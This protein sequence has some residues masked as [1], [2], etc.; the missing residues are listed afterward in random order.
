M[1]QHNFKKQLGQNFLTKTEPILDFIEA[2]DPQAAD[3]ILEIGPGNGALSEYIAANVAYLHLL[4]IDTE[5][6]P[7]LQ[8]KFGFLDN[9][10]I[11]NQDV[12]KLNVSEFI[13]D[14]Q[15]NKIAGALPYNISKLIIAQF[16][17]NPDLAL[18]RCVFILQKEVAHDYAGTGKKGTFLNHLYS[19]YNDIYLIA[20]IDRQ[21][22]YPT[23]Q[24]DSSIIIFKPLPVEKIKLP[25]TDRASYTKFLKNTFLNPRKK[26]IKNLSNIY[27]S[28][29]WQNIFNSLGLG[30]NTRVEE[31]ST[32]QVL[33]LYQH[34]KAHAPK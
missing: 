5:L 31:L 27:R 13:K 4:E 1:K 23:P 8:E 18:E 29:N 11:A 14:Q 30:E 3:R 7:L 20:D 26:L 15:I 17:A 32:T 24:V 19:L 10:T 16:C 12:L 25:D 33:N 21:S 34:F 22:F 28:H 9:V 6:I 2:L